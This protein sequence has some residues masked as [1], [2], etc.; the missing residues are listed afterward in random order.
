VPDSVRLL[1][2]TLLSAKAEKF[3][4]KA[5]RRVRRMSFRLDWIDFIFMGF[6]F[7]VVSSLVE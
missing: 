4:A 2:T 7:L 1:V 3:S 5:Q 6:L